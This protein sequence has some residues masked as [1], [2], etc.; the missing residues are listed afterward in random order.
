MLTAVAFL[1]ALPATLVFT[2]YAVE[3]AAGLRPLKGRGA[4]GG[5]PR[6]V[7]LVPAHNEAAAIADTVD[8]LREHLPSTASILVVADNC[9]DDTASRARKAGARVVER[10]DPGRRGK[11]YALA[12][13]RDALIADPPRCVVVLDADCRMEPGGVERI[14]R[15]CVAWGAPV[16]S[17]NLL[18]GDTRQPVMV[19]ISNFAFLIKNLVRQQ[20][21]ARLG[22][23]AV[24]TGTGMAIPW[25]PFR[26]APLATG[27]IVEDLGLG[28]LLTRAGWRPRFLPTV[29]T[30][31]DPAAR[32]DM[33]A[34]R[35]R[36]EGGFLATARRRALPLIRSG[37]AQRS[38]PE[39][40]LGMHLLVPPLA[41]L[42]ALG[43]AIAVVTAMLGWAGAGWWP[44]A[45]LGGAG[46]VAA[47]LTLIAWMRVGRNVLAP[48]ALLQIP[49]YVLFKIPIYL[50]LLR[51]SPGEWNRTRRVGEDVPGR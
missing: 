43:S 1:V 4:A 18:R 33:L 47:A 24:L 30:W 20:G 21:M 44:V 31:S 37:L 15:A 41:L 22:K 38:R 13:G 34:Q 16:Q 36:W 39:L 14:A 12:F 26:T 23:T 5:C 29:R 2:I 35:S 27:D 45:M 25:A 40:W 8:A 17:C 48:T 19:Q 10:H 49:F 46:G 42:F 6:T 7:I 3:V 32:G 9:A 28:I 11:G 51:G 50:R